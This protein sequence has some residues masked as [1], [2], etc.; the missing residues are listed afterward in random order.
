MNHQPTTRHLEDILKSI[1]DTD[2]LK[3]YINSV[4]DTIPFDSFIEYFKSLPKTQTIVPAD[5]F[6][7]ANLDRAYC[8]KIW[9]GKKRPGRDKILAI[10]IAAG[11]DNDE[12]R[13][14]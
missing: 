5:L 10:C 6:R 11:L 9:N 3:A 1:G 2:E 8:Y 12:T 13:R 4:N 14:A 7:L